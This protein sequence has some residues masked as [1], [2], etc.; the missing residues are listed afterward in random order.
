MLPF[1]Y[2]KKM[3]ELFRR[4]TSEARTIINYDEVFSKMGQDTLVCID[5]GI[6]AVAR[7]LLAERG[8]W[9]VTYAVNYYNNGY[10]VPNSLQMADIRDRIAEFLEGTNDMANCS[11][12][13]SSLLAIASAINGLSS[14]CCNGTG[15]AGTSQPAPDTAEGIGYPGLH[16]GPAPEGFTDWAE[17][18]TYKCDMATKIAEDIIKDVTWIAGSAAVTAWLPV[19]ATTL[20][21]PVPFDDLVAIAGLLAAIAVDSTV[22]IVFGAAL[23][24]LNAAKDDLICALYWAGDS[25][26]SRANA[27][28]IIDSEITNSLAASAIKQMLGYYT[29]NDLYS[30]NQAERDKGLP[31]GDCSGCGL[32]V[33]LLYGTVV[34]PMA[35][36]W[37]FDFQL[38]AS[39][40]RLTIRLNQPVDITW[41]DVVGQVNA[42]F[43]SSSDFQIGTC[44]EAPGA[45]SGGTYWDLWNSD[46][47]PTAGT[48]FEDVRYISI[49]SEDAAPQPSTWFLDWSPA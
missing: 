37:E 17:Y 31:V 8:S 5:Q 19:L 33:D 10:D 32:V 24:E 11:D 41:S 28:G 39:A 6:L 13:N 46:T 14:G 48:V 44:P 38:A 45:C 12:F 21:T 26:T 25:A 2:I 43:P 3:N 27:V 1:F 49:L 40:W 7:Q 42:G 4:Y 30:N 22:A 29:I 34:D 16:T 35:Q 15:G 36:P 47:P 20:L 9:A 23:I 18:D